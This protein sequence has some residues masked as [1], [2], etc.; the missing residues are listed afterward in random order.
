M[1][2]TQMTNGRLMVLFGSLVVFATFGMRGASAQTSALETQVSAYDQT[3]D[4]KPSTC[5]LSYVVIHTETLNAPSK[6]VG[7]S[8]SLSWTTAPGHKFF[9]MNKLV[10]F[11]FDGGKPQQFPV[12]Y[13]F[14][15]TESG[16]YARREQRYFDAEGGGKIAGYDATTAAD[17]FGAIMRSPSLYVSYNRHPGEQDVRVPLDIRGKL[18][19]AD[20]RA[21]N[22]C[23]S[24]IVA[25]ARI[26]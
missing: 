1:R 23:M 12:N 26:E 2:G 14:I 10:G 7:I 22:T 24:A 18:S 9:A 13:H 8:G 19:P 25:Q 11:D 20:E 21:F 6:I 17:V 4:G 3:A 5:G 15:S 16:N